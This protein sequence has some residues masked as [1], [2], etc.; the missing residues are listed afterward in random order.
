[1]MKL[2]IFCALAI[3]TINCFMMNE[4]KL[5]PFERLISD[6][7]DGMNPY[8]ILLLVNETSKE[9]HLE[10]N[11]I[12]YF[13]IQNFVSIII[14]FPSF[15]IVS[16]IMDYP[17]LG[18]PRFSTLFVLIY[19]PIF[20]K[21]VSNLSEVSNILDG[22]VD[23]LPM[24]IR[25]R[26]LI[27]L[28]ND[29][30]DKNEDI[31]NF[32]REA[33]NKKFLD[34]TIMQITRINFHFHKIILHYYNPFKNLYEAK[35]YNESC[36]LF[37]DKLT[38]MNGYGLKAIFTDD[39]PTIYLQRDE[40]GSIVGAGGTDYWSIDSVSSVLN[41]SLQAELV[42]YGYYNYDE[43][44]KSVLRGDT[45]FTGIQVYLFDEV[46]MA[47]SMAVKSD[48]YCAV[49][50]ILPAPGLGLSSSS[51]MGIVFTV[52]YIVSLLVAAKLLRFDRKIYTWTNIM[53]VILGFTI[54]RHPTRI[55]ERV[56]MGCI[57]FLSITYTT[58]FYAKMTDK[59][60]QTIEEIPLNSFA[61]LD[62][63]GLVP[64]VHKDVFQYTYDVYDNG[65]EVMKSL[66]E[67]TGF[68]EDPSVCA[69]QLAET[70][71]IACIMPE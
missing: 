22:Y 44:I 15:R 18:S 55:R 13:L 30:V 37:P 54:T 67:K 62:N 45:D 36:E 23:I 50:P 42:G 70:K 56:V 27:L 6:I 24:P 20:Q 49:V 28:I 68:I 43:A 59:N 46:P 26:W 11:Y 39:P 10:I 21:N 35:L 19:T 16:Y 4:I 34:L 71:D 9:A 64:M 51:Y 32:L 14:D 41:F 65:S 58:T 2:L 25:P 1:M 40:S 3:V 7:V 47:R 8:Q 33:W 29:I 57:I 66:K 5:N 69:D 31:N 63:A 53:Q 61:D 48:G 38:D 52:G 60:L 12:I 17:N